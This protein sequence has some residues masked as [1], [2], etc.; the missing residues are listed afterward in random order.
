MIKK[1]VYEAFSG[2]AVRFHSSPFKGE[3]EARGLWEGDGGEFA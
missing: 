2:S 3:S 1:Y